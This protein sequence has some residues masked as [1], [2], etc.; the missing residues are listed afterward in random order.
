MCLPEVLRTIRHSP[1]SATLKSAYERCFGK[2]STNKIDLAINPLVPIETDSLKPLDPYPNIDIENNFS[3]SEN[4]DK[5][6]V[7]NNKDKSTR[8][9]IKMDKYFIQNVNNINEIIPDAEIYQLEKDL[10]VRL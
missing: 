5:I 10:N 3:I 7:T 1:D 8:S 4:N 9:L 6:T 2:R